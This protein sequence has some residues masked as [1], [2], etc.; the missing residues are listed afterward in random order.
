M[1]LS[2]FAK[3]SPRAKERMREFFDKRLKLSFGASPVHDDDDD[4]DDDNDD[5][6]YAVTLEGAKDNI[7]AGITAESMILSHDDVKSVF[8]PIFAEITRLVQN[9]VTTVEKNMG[10]PITVCLHPKL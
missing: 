6:A 1:L 7:D 10:Q 8:D 2:A 5:A 3:M 9:Q 4:D